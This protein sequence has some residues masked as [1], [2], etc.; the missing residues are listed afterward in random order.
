MTLVYSNMDE[1]LLWEGRK[2][3]KQNCVTRISYIPIG[4]FFQIQFI[5]SNVP[6]IRG[7]LNSAHVTT[8]N[9]FVAYADVVV[10]LL[11]QL[12]YLQINTPDSQIRT[13][14]T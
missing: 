8:N 11:L 3:R 7:Q 5:V 2:I 9:V 13:H 10:M 14:K 6:G 12:G 4:N 1:W